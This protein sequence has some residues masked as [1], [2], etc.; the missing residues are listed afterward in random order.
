MSEL[1]VSMCYGLKAL[2]CNS[3]HIKSLNMSNH[4]YLEKLEVGVY[5]SNS[6]I[7]IDLSNSIQIKYLKFIIL[8]IVR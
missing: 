6:D 1:D 5:G 8:T 7:E 2:H 4:P 3:N